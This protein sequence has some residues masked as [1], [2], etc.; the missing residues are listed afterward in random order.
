MAHIGRVSLPP[1]LDPVLPGTDPH[2]LPELAGEIVAVGE[3]A[4][5]GC[6]GH[7]DIVAPQPL[8]RL[9]HPH[10]DDVFDRGAGQHSS[11][12]PHERAFPTCGRCA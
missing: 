11:E 6:F 1:V 2:D 3:T 8:G 4:I 5:E 10:A 12:R 9:Q 7:P